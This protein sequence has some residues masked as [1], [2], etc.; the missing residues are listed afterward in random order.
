[1]A[2]TTAADAAHDLHALGADTHLGQVGE[3]LQCR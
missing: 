2:Q 3:Q 1:M